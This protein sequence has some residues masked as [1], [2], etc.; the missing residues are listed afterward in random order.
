M[1]FL[2]LGVIKDS[3]GLDGTLKIFSTTN[4]SNK[5][6]KVG[7]IVFLVNPLTNEKQEHVVLAFRHSGLFDFVKLDGINSPEDAKS[8]KTYEIHVEK[9][10]KDLEEGTYFYSDLRGCKVYDQDRNELGT[11]KEV[12][13]FPAQLTLRVMRKGK[14]DFFVPFIKQF[15]KDVNIENKAIIIEKIEGLLWKLQF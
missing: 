15:I 9:D 5:R 3:F 1:E 2:S 4:M 7:N 11:V 12:E 6:Y 14:Q 13:E 8:L 10:R